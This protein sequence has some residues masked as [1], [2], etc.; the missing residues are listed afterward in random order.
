MRST[1]LLIAATAA[2]SMF[3]ATAAAAAPATAN[4][5]KPIQVQLQPEQEVGDFSGVEG[6][7]VT[8]RFGSTPVRARS[9][10]TASSTGSTRRWH[11]STRRPAGS[12]GPVVVGFDALIDGSGFA[13]CVDVDRQLV[14]DI[15][16]NPSDYYVNV[17]LG[18][19][20]TPEFFEGVRGQ[21]S[22]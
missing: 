4:T 17:H 9:V 18:G 12:N 8:C 11:T 20:G 1:K 16:R 6:A 10:S 19:G 15:I 7:S 21:L 3:G 13:G 14:R 22:R 5:G 2:L